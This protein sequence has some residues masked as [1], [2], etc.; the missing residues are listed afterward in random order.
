MG[1]GPSAFRWQILETGDVFKSNDIDFLFMAFS[2]VL[3][4]SSRRRIR[5]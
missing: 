4:N 5:H 1:E 2:Q 3:R